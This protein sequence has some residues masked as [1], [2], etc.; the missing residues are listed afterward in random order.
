[1]G[2][3]RINEVGKCVRSTETEPYTKH[4]EYHLTKLW[5]QEYAYVHRSLEFTLDP[6]GFVRDPLEAVSCGL[7]H[8]TDGL[9]NGRQ[10]N[11]NESDSG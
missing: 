10:T 7:N 3:K 6:S 11:G 9:V 2:E 1:M 8:G 5:V 4:F